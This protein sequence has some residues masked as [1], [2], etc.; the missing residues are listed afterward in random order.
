MFAALFF[1]FFFFFFVTRR[2]EDEM[3][4]KL[5]FNKSYQSELIGQMRYF[6]QLHIAPRQSFCIRTPAKLS[7]SFSLASTESTLTYHQESQILEVGL[8]PLSFFLYIPKI[9]RFIIKFRDALKLS[10]FS[11]SF[12]PR[13]P[14]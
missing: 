13:L 7:S 8:S 11:F 4:R 2:E 9:C 5:E 3:R 12:L 6:L 10:I 14:Q 1:S